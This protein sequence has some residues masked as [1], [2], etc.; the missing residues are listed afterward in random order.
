MANSLYDSGR[1]GFLA[2]DLDWD[3]NTI[4]HVLID[5]G[6]DTPNVTTDDNLDDLIAGARIATSGAYTSKTTTAGVA[7]AV[8][9]TRFPQKWTS[10]LER[11]VFAVASTCTSR[12]VSLIAP[13][14]QVTVTRSEPLTPPPSVTATALGAGAADQVLGELFA[15]TLKTKSLAVMAA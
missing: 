12:Y 6:T 4:K 15:P 14:A 8:S 7:D 11:P 1:A 5:H 2:G 10:A 3:A 13:E 9:P